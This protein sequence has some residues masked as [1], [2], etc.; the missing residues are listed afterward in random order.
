MS[1]ARRVV[2]WFVIAVAAVGGRSAIAQDAATGPDAVAAAR[3]ESFARDVDVETLGR[4]AVQ[5]DG[6]IK[7]FESFAREILSG[8]AG[9][10]EIHGHAASFSYVDLMLRSPAYHHAA[11][12]HVKKKPIRA[13]IADAVREDARPADAAEAAALDATLSEF[14]ETGLISEP[15]LQ[16]PAVTETLSRLRRDLLR[17]AKFVEALDTARLLRRPDVL[18]DLLQIVPPPG[19]TTQ[20][21]WITIDRYV[22]LETEEGSDAAAIQASVRDSWRAFVHGWLD[23]D[24]ARVNEALGHLAVTLPEVNRELYP[25]GDRLAWEATYFRLKNLTWIWLIYGVALVPLLLAVVYRWPAARWAGMTVFL[26]AFAGHTFALGLRWYVSGRWPNSNMFEAVTTAA[27]FGGVAAVFLEILLRRTPMRNLFAFTSAAAS[28]VALMATRLFP[29]ALD[30]SIGNRMPVLHDVWL[31]IHTNVI[32]FSYCL[33]FMAAVVGVIY[34]VYRLLGGSREHARAGGAGAL[35]A[36]RPDGSGVLAGPRASAGQVLDGTLMVL[37]ELSFILLWAG[38]VM[39]AIWA[40][41][42]W[43]RP[44]GW[45]P[46]EVF[47]LNTFIVFAVLVHARIVAKDKALW[48]ALIAIVGCGVMLFNWI[49][50]NF[51]I[52]GL[53]SY[54]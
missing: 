53:H 42:S 16:G 20:D 22:A 43:G 35:I 33:I 6:R 38:I 7:S 17:G 8:I 44:W 13:A 47:A 41:H 26:L 14:M 49:V 39:G 50:I 18:L 25:D 36:R 28:A 21:P 30:A 3:A 5:T 9:P 52:A 32:I 34:L 1:R 4:L 2:A 48:T 51:V 46:K 10:H 15:L 29:L 27:W 45:D 31:Y 40:D 12:L 11:I 24:A 37:M 19:G 23:Q 54:G